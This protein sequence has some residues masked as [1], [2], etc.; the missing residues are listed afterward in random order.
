[1][2]SRLGL[3]VVQE[4]SQTH[5]DNRKL[6]ASLPAEGRK[7]PMLSWLRFGWSRGVN[8]GVEWVGAERQP[9]IGS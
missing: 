2:I 6:F 9:A 7:V 3:E 5:T 1:M 8:H 4:T